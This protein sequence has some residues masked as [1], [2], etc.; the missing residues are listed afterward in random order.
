MRTCSCLFGGLFDEEDD[1]LVCHGDERL[2][3]LRR[4]DGDVVHLQDYVAQLQGMTDLL[5]ECKEALVNYSR[6]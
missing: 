4:P 3:V 6:L 1:A 2:Q 5:R